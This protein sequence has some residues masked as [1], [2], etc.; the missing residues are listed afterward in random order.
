MTGPVSD[1]DF[2]QAD[3]EIGKAATGIMGVIE[4]LLG[5]TAKLE[6]V[7][8][9]YV[10]EQLLL[11]LLRKHDFVQL[12]DRI[13]QPGPVTLQLSNALHDYRDAQFQDR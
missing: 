9:D 7:A 2:A 3:R 4:G 5:R 10:V 11:E 12:L 8:P 6:L 1:R 13:N